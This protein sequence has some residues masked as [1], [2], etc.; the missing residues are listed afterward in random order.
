MRNVE[1]KFFRPYKV[2]SHVF[3]VPK[4]YKLENLLG[5]GS[6]GVVCSATDNKT[7]NKVAIKKILQP[8]KYCPIL[9]RTIREIKLLNFMNQENIIDI[10]DLFPSVEV[11]AV[12]SVYMVSEQMS[13]DLM[14]V[15]HSSAAL[16]EEHIKYIL[17]QLL[18]G[19]RYL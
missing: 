8:M 6:Y 17:F 2:D 5:M 19:L 3:I 7:G 9:K 12:E 14:Q 18:D 11:K 10:L 16:S 13:S 1:G 4:R 15:I